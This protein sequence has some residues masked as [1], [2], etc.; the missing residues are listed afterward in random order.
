MRLTKISTRTGDG[1]VTGLAD[2]TRVGKDNLRI[3]AMGE[4]DELNSMIGLILTE[5]LPAEFG[6]MLEAI[7][8]DLFEFGAELCQPGQFRIGRDHVAR[9]DEELANA[10]ASLPP[11][12]EFIL[13][14]GSRAAALCQVTRAVC[15]RAERS[16]VSLSRVEAVGED[17]LKY[18][19]R[20]SDLLF[21]YARAINRAQSCPD[22][23][24]KPG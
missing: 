11:L 16:L 1:G 17:A 10:N 21:V 3:C 20:L 5:S 14:G 19:N 7:Q 12:A 6:G 24:W 13:P 9:L 2:G 4:V 23:L 8:H 22:K 18:L 15:R